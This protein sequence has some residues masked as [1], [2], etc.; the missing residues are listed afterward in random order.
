MNDRAW[1]RSRA[2]GP[3][4]RSS[5]SC[6]TSTPTARTRHPAG[7][8]KRFARRGARDGARAR[9][10]APASRTPPPPASIAAS[11]RGSMPADIA[12]WVDLYDDEIAFVDAR[13]G[14]LVE[15]FER[16]RAPRARPRSSSPRRRPR[17]ELPRARHSRPLPCRSTT[18]RSAPPGSS[19][20]GHPAKAWSATRS[21]RTS[22]SCR[23][24]STSPASRSDAGRLRRALARRADVASRRGR[25]RRDCRRAPSPVGARRS[26][27]ATS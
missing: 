20:A 25:R 22:T 7:G 18:P 24:C 2:T 1:R 3:A 4:N 6:T 5:S 14:E 11:P 27:G 26:T 13:I 19:P 8:R 10:C 21:P 23:R 15:A 9:R 17:R 16:L 12:H